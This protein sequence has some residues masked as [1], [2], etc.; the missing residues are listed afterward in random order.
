M[1]TVSL[2]VPDAAAAE[3]QKLADA[4]NATHKQS[5]TP[6]QYAILVL[7]RGLCAEATSLR[8]REIEEANLAAL[9]TI[10]EKMEAIT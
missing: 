3:V 5:L 1:L 4:H 7:V 9:R 8:L 6:K 2:N 10:R